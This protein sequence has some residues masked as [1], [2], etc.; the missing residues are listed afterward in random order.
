MS[1]RDE[2]IK[3]LENKICRSA[4]IEA[5]ISYLADFIIEDRNRIVQPLVKYKSDVKLWDRRG[6]GL[7]SHTI[8]DEAIDETLKLAGVS[9]G[10]G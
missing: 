3:E 9:N 6:W 10:K 1:N 8:S 4:S 2:L 7:D 5:N